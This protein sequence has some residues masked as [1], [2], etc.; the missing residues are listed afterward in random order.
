MK[1]VVQDSKSFLEVGIGS[2]IV[3]LY[4]ARLRLDVSCV[5]INPDAVT[6]T[7]KNFEANKNQG[8]FVESDLFAALGY[9]KFDIIFWNHPWQWGDSVTKELKTEMTFDPG[10]KLVERYIAEGEKYFTEK[11]SILLGSSCYANPDLLKS[12]AN[13]YTMIPRLKSLGKR[14][15]VKVM[16]KNITSFD[17]F[18][19]LTSIFYCIYY[20]LVPINIS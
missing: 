12:I 2:G 20:R 5:D 9:K 16:K 13:K 3:S 15:L 14:L 18:L 10:Y 6:T 1:K 17:L 4:M 11:G 7:K 8:Y 19:H